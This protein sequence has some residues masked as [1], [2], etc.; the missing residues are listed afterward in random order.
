MCNQAYQVI[1][2]ENVDSV[3]L[4]RAGGYVVQHCQHILTLLLSMV[5]HLTSINFD[6]I[7]KLISEKCKKLAVTGD[8]V[9][10]MGELVL[11]PYVHFTRPRLGALMQ[12]TLTTQG[13]AKPLTMSLECAI[14][15]RHMKK[16]IQLSL[17]GHLTTV[18]TKWLEGWCPW[19]D[20]YLLTK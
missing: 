8:E 13:Q 7:Y 17:A 6:P 1:S 11:L 9:L 5:F 2:A 15:S 14:Q 4:E 3:L 10:A 18:I 16:P 19:E 12:G 20:D